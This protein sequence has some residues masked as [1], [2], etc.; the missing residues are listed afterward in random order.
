MESVLDQAA[1][2]RRW[3]ES[4]NAEPAPEGQLP[5]LAVASGKGG[6]GK[7]FLSVNLAL[8]L[9]ERGRAPFLVDLD[10]GLANV[11]VALGV[12]SQRNLAHVLNGECSLAEATMSYCGL[13][14]LPNGCGDSFLTRLDV[15][16]RRRLFQQL[17]AGKPGR[18]LLIADTH[19]G[20]GAATLDVL[21][22]ADV[23]V[24]ISTPEP[25][26]LTD[27]YA[28]LKVLSQGETKGQVLLVV[29]QAASEAQACEAAEHL[30]RVAQRFLGS[31]VRY[32]GC[33]LADAAV[34]RSVHQQRPVLQSAPQSLATRGV[35]ELAGRLLPQLQARAGAGKEVSR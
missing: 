17:R 6:V 32:C 4:R 10:W 3:R 20:I 11:D 27:T 1:S 33:I 24:V 19:P 26:A 23:T 28:L 35:M 29:N 34:S 14:L 13:E 2:L 15:S 31:G 25:T 7:T 21:R 18:D 5:M 8:A 9:M 22:E 30:D 12:A 16:Q